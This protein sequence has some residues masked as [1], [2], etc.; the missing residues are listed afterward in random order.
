M[1]LLLRHFTLNLL[2]TYKCSVFELLLIKK[3]FIPAISKHETNKVYVFTVM[4]S[5]C[6][7][8]SFWFGFFYF[9]FLYCYL[10][11]CNLFRFSILL[12]YFFYFYFFSVSVS[13]SFTEVWVT[14][15]HTILATKAANNAGK[16][17]SWWHLIIRYS[18]CCQTRR[19]SEGS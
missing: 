14:R 2:L 5:S 19:E 18:K 1:F 15:C 6:F 7:S 8:V 17:D 4:E 10:S 9:I 13:F 16:K 11:S 12:F 3:S